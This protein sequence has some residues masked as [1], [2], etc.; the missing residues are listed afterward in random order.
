MLDPEVVETARRIACS[1]DIDEV[2][3][4]IKAFHNRRDLSDFAR[5]WSKPLVVIRGDQDV[6]PPHAAA[7]ETAS[8]EFGELHIIEGAG[9]YTSLEKPLRVHSII[10]DVLIGLA[11]VSLNAVMHQR[12]W[13]DL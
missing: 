4:G 8:S 3:R 2:V 12:K 5:S 9:H 11:R 13:L 10:R 6:T 1:L 7:A